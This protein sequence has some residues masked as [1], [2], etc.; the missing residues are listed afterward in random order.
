MSVDLY[1][2]VVLHGWLETGVFDQ[3]DTVDIIIK[4]QAQAEHTS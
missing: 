3:Q 1:Q 4:F 2:Y